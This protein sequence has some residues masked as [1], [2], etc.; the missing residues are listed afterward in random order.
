MRLLRTLKQLPEVE[1]H[2]GLSRW[3][4]TTI[5]LETGLSA[6]EATSRADE[7]HH[8]KERRTLVLVQRTDRDERARLLG[9]SCSRCR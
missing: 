9:Q 4:R 8:A 1:T 7:A 2:L 5:E 3:A 6:R